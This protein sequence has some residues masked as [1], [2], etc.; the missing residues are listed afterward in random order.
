MQK[1]LFDFLRQIFKSKTITVNVIVISAFTVYLNFIGIKL[2]PEENEMLIKVVPL[3]LGGV[4]VVLRFFTKKP[5]KD[6]NNI[7]QR[8]CT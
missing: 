4:N 3:M 7:V 5:W 6:K 1:L 2:T 8:R